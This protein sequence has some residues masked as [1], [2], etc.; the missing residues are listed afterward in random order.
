MARLPRIYVDGC[1]YHIVQRGNNHEACF[2]RE[3]DY[4]FYLQKLREAAEKYRVRVHAFVLMTNHVHLLVTPS[5]KEGV[6]RMM[7]SLGRSFVRYMNI[8]Y[9][10][11]GTL[12]EGRYKSSLVGGERYLLAVY[13]YIEL[14]PLRAN[15]VTL[16]GEY[17]WSSYR[18]NAMGIHIELVQEHPVYLGLSNTKAGRLLAYREL[19]ERRIPPSLIQEIRL[20]ANKEWVLGDKT[21]N[22]QIE[23]AIGRTINNDGWGGDRKSKNF[24]SGSRTLTS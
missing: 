3:A 5:D 20:C 23:R 4:A 15:M 17:P 11:T 2:Y 9:K 22:E 24:C 16:P 1:A 6:A 12:W 19:F 13:R 8:T 14:N 7:Q 21:F 18:H 10:R